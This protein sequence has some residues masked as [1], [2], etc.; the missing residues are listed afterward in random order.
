MRSILNQLELVDKAD[1]LLILNKAS[2]A[3]LVIQL[4]MAA[5]KRIIN[6]TLQKSSSKKQFYLGDK[7]LLLEADSEVTAKIIIENKLFFLKTVVKKFDQGFYF[8]NFDNL[9]ELIRRKK[10]R[11]AIPLQWSQ[12]ALIQAADSETDPKVSV[13]IHEMSAAGM[14]LEVKTDLPKFEKNQKIRIQFKVFRRAEVLV[15]AKI[16]HVTKS[17]VGGPTI[18]VEF[19]EASKL[20]ENKIQNVCDDLAFFY[21]S[22]AR[23]S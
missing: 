11:F 18:G 23:T 12:T 16:I 14:K 3:G 21:T 2:D 15:S 1:A 10:P 8:D 20:V 6:A 13:F 17:K 19:S 22:E 7:F 9:F 4:K 5:E